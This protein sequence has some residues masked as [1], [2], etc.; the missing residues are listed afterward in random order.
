VGHAYGGCVALRYALDHPAD[1][2]GLVLL[3]PGAFP[4]GA[5]V[6]PAYYLPEVPILGPLAL[7][8]LIVPLGR[9]L[10]PSMLA[11]SFSPEK[12]PFRYREALTGFSRQPAQFAVYASESRSIERDLAEIAPRYGEIKVPVVIVGGD[13]DQVVPAVEDGRRL[14]AAIPQSTLVLLRN[15][16]HEIQHKH[17]EVVTQA[18]AEVARLREARGVDGA[19]GGIRTPT[20]ARPAAP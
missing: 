12:T 13:A 16:G 20:G 11:A 19:E 2:G 9:L 3:A 1:L 15:T 18:I 4:T 10:G 17:P 7:S 8:T 6:N 14:H 5:P